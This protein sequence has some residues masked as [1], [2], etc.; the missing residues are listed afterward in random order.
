VDTRTVEVVLHVTQQG[1]LVTVLVCAP[2][3]LLSMAVGLFVSIVQA[4]TQV[5]EHSLTFVPK[6]VVVLG[7]LAAL[8]PWLG[9]ALLHFAR[10]CF[11]GFP[12]LA[13]G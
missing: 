2:P 1:L 12:G 4:V 13:G 7:A 3:L 9:R 11:E 10:L 5:Q 8:G 6:L